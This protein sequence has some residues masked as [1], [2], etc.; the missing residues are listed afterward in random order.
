MTVWDEKLSRAVFPESKDGTAPE[1]VSRTEPSERER[2][3]KSEKSARIREPMGWNARLAER[4][5][6][7]RQRWISKDVLREKE[8]DRRRSR[9]EHPRSS[10]GSVLANRGEIW[11]EGVVGGGWAM[12]SASSNIYIP[13]SSWGD[14]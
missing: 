6:E 2:E 7:R 3:R 5:K 4:V 9:Y 13:L 10:T 8:A 11:M 1:E 14:G 12:S